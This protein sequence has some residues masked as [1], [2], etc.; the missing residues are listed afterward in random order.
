MT[1]SYDGRMHR[2]DKQVA[3]PKE[4][5][6]EHAMPSFFVGHCEWHPNTEENRAD[7]LAIVLHYN[8]LCGPKTHWIGAR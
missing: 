6:I 4:I 8:I 7:L 2:L 3:L 1:D 5:R